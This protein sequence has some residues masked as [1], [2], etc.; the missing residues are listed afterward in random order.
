MILLL[1][2]NNMIINGN[3]V[4]DIKELKHYVMHTFKMKDL[5]PLTCFPA[6][7]ISRTKDGNSVSQRK[8][9]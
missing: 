7:E 4:E 9:A 3:D 5:G 1:Y 2:G 6:L 8:Y